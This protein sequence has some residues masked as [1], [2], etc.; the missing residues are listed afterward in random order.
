MINPPNPNSGGLGAA[1][2]RAPFQITHG[3][4]SQLLGQHLYTIPEIQRPYA[5]KIK[6]AEELVRDLLKIDAAARL[7][8]PQPQHYLGTLVVVTAAGKPDDVVDGQQRLT[9]VSVLIGQFI[10]ALN[11]LASRAATRGA[12]N[13][14]NVA[15]AQKFSNIEQNARNKVLALQNLVQRP[16]GFNQAQQQ[17]FVPRIEV[18]PEIVG[19]FR[20]L[21]DGGDGLSMAG[22]ENR[23]PAQDLRQIANYLFNDYVTGRGYDALDE[24]EQ[25]RHLNSRADQVTEG[26]IWVR[27]GTEFA[28]SAAELFESLN[29]R[30]R[31]LNVLGLV[32]VWL[33]A[34]L[35]QV[36]AQNS[37]YKQ[38]ANDFREL[39][40]DDDALAIQYF[41]DFYRI[42]ALEDV[43]SNIEAKEL[44]LLSR[45]KIFQDP[46]LAPPAGGKTPNM[47]SIIRDEVSLMKRLWPTWDSLMHGDKSAA[48][49]DRSLHRLPK[50]CAATPNR[51]WINTR[52]NLLLDS[53]W[54]AHKLVYPFLTEASEVLAQNGRFND[55]EDL[56]HDIE[57]FFFRIKSICN[58]SP[59]LI[60]ALYFKHLTTLKYGGTLSLVNMRLEMKNLLSRHAADADFRKGLLEKCVYGSGTDLTKYFLSVIQSYAFSK[61]TAVGVPMSPT[62]T[63]MLIDLRKWQIEHIVP[64]NPPAGQH[65][66]GPTDVHRLG[67]L[68]LLPPD[69]NQLLTNLDF[70]SKRTKVASEIAINHDL[71]I[72][73]SKFVFTSP[74]YASTQWN[75]SDCKAREDFL[76]DRA[77]QIF[78]I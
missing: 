39:S 70:P 43:K 2:Y 8:N 33:L 78:V 4:V 31:P 42:R 7:G 61:P 40:D 23:L 41:L 64:Q 63:Q 25:F 34:T 60:K 48:P 47:E 19:T 17:I 55:F 76:L 65:A 30:G 15:V 45:A 28:D 52:L 18:S 66:L 53:Q 12:E 26:L 24:V 6:N 11:D 71:P 69:W 46:V 68:C 54:L 75:V 3:P 35:K 59:A 67:N 77:E 50:V 13:S 51:V 72:S 44:S 1:A 36:G 16:A 58:V 57:K 74:S 37:T 62:K 49:R 9:T 29:A 20:D 22:T 73:D 56:V 38:V 5:W 32:K 27:L 14:A 10:R 21:I